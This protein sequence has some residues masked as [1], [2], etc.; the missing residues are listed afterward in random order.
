MFLGCLL[1]LNLIFVF[2]Y[3]QVG[4]AVA[5]PVARALGYT[6]GLAFEG[7]TSTSDDPLYKLPD[8][9]PMI[10]DRVSSVSSEDDV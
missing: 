7:S 8:K 2:R 1:D 4:N 3:I 9:F 10:R 6:L 5:V